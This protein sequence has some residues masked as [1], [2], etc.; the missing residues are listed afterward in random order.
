MKRA[1][2]KLHLKKDDIVQ[3]IAG[4]EKGKKGKQKL[5]F[6]K[7]IKDS[8]QLYMILLKNAQKVK[9]S[10]SLDFQTKHIKMRN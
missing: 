10:T 9:Q 2:Y 1:A 8:K 7:D 3:V 4:K 6:T 5:Q